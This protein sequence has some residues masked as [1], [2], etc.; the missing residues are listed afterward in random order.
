MRG[1]RTLSAISSILAFTGISYAESW[2]FVYF[3]DTR[4][5]TDVNTTAVAELANRAVAEGAKFV[6]VGGDLAL[7]GSAA[8][9][10][11][12]KS[13]MAPAYNAGIGVYPVI[14]NHDANDVTAFINA[15]GADLPDN[16]PAGE[17]NRT[18][19][20]TYNNALV[21]GLD[22]Y[23]GTSHTITTAKQAWIT[24][25]LQQRDPAVAQQV[26]TFGHDPAFKVYHSDC[27]DDNA[28]TR[29]TF[30]NS[31]KIAGGRTYFC[32]HDHFYDHARIDD[33]DGNPN[34]DVHQYVSGAGGAPFYTGYSYNG[35]NSPFTPVNVLHDENRYGYVLV[36]IDG[37]TAKL[38]YKY[39][40]GPNAYVASTDVFTYTA[41]APA[42]LTWDGGGGDA[43]WN[44]ANNWNL[45]NVPAGG[46]PLVFSGATRQTTMNNSDLIHV[47]LVSFNNGGFVCSGNPLTLDAGMT[48]TG[49]NTWGISSTLNAPQ[50]FT[51]NAA[52]T[53]TV[54]G[55]I[56]TNGKDLAL[57]GAGNHVI[58]GIVSGTG[59][60]VKSGGGRLTFNAAN[61]YTGITTVSGGTLA[62]GSA[63]ALQS[64]LIVL[65]SETLFDVS[66]K[67]GGF[68]LPAGS[69]LKGTGAI[70]GN[71]IVHGT[72]VP[73]STPGVQTVLG[74]YT[75][76]GNLVLEIAGV[77][78]GAGHDQVRLSGP[79]VYNAAL[80]GNLSLDWTNF[81][82]SAAD[83]MLWII[84]NETPGALTG[85]FGNYGNRASLGAHDGRDW[86][87][88]YGADFATASLTGGNDVVLAPVPEPSTLLL[89]GLGIVGFLFRA[90][91]R[92]KE[93]AQ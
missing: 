24:Q 81:G 43:N 13:T 33:G 35:A 42:T 3:A 73:G 38:T 53:L 17:V 55:A 83:T 49:N 61:A 82:G 70:L 80:G 56:H 31:L 58:S 10:A 87:I 40:T 54:T 4:S 6:L 62:L 92:E 51:S 76:A 30:I 26:F 45:N 14:G 34:N 9:F 71:F 19:A 16:G 90:C 60:L 78:A 32:G 68:D 8:N 18:F 88:W 72:H 20:L 67:A 50:T 28:T 44:T 7:S 21:L 66:A 36:E 89:L 69:T 37:P 63:A 91:Q 93:A 29:N 41:A 11:L 86:Q 79:V 65:A 15:F 59:N 25:Q 57:A 75:M 52:G 77:I 27:L 74:N 47:G 5:S 1:L 46:S 22:E 2:K 12:W 48:S 64:T 84:K 85:E 23:V 39:R